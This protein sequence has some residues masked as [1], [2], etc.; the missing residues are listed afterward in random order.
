MDVPKY[1]NSHSIYHKNIGRGQHRCTPG[2][3]KEISTIYKDMVA[4]SSDELT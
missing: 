2:R 1:P 4:C 3:N